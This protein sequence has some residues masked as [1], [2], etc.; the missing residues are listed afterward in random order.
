MDIKLFGRVLTPG[1]R[2]QLQDAA[3]ATAL[4][5]EAAAEASEEPEQC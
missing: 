1:C 4:A 5:A 2:V 3:A